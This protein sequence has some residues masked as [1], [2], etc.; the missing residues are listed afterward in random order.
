MLRSFARNAIPHHTH[1]RRTLVC[2]DDDVYDR[3]VAD[4]V[5]VC[6]VCVLNVEPFSATVC[7]TLTRRSTGIEC[8][9][10]CVWCGVRSALVRRSLAACAWLSRA[11]HT[12][13][14]TYNW[15]YIA[16]IYAHT[17]GTA[18]CFQQLFVLVCG[19]DKHIS[20][21]RLYFMH[22]ISVV[23]RSSAGNEFSPAS[24]SSCISM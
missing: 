24:S 18:Y 13:I 10:V 6:R 9:C 4:G 2:A 11:V 8:V 16:Y 3:G 1:D 17:G 21:I 19:H 23:R 12:R 22:N 7:D 15:T 14:Y 5:S 20:R